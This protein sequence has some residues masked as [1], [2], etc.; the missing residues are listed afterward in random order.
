MGTKDLLLLWIKMNNAKNSQYINKI[1]RSFLLF[2][3]IDHQPKQLLK[4][5]TSFNLKPRLVL[6]LPQHHLLT[7]L[8]TLKN[9]LVRGKTPY[10]VAKCAY[11]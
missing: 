6:G 5:K 4:F 9:Q 3:L 10:Y 11:V 8:H 1:N 7:A 2:S